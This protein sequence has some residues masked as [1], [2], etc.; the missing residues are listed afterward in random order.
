[1]DAMQNLH[2]MDASLLDGLMT[3]TK[4]GLHLLAARSSPTPRLPQ[5]PNWPASS[6]CS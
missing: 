1:M 3:S 4:D 6:I 5:P 2:R